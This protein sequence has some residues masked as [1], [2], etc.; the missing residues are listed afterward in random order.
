MDV[1]LICLV[2][3]YRFISIPVAYAVKQVDREST[4]F[5]V[6]LEGRP[7]MRFLS[8]WRFVVPVEQV[9]FEPCGICREAGRS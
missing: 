9:Y 8:S 2:G 3:S 1:V 7:R 4:G 5:S 6:G